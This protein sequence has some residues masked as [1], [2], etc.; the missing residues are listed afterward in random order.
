MCFFFLSSLEK[1]IKQRGLSQAL[2]SQML[3]RFPCQLLASTNSPKQ[4]KIYQ[5]AMTNALQKKKKNAS[6]PQKEPPII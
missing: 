3:I 2:K 1:K 5:L 4:F 6:S